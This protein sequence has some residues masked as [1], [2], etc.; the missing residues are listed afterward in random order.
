MNERRIWL[1]TPVEQDSFGQRLIQRGVPVPVI[2][3]MCTNPTVDG[4]PLFD[5]VEDLNTTDCANS[6]LRMVQA[7]A[8]RA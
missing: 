6:L 7:G 1:G 3:K 5:L 2:E 8:I 4:K